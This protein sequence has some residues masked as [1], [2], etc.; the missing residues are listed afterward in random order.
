LWSHHAE[1]AKL[2]V[3]S[4]SIKAGVKPHTITLNGEDQDA[5]IADANMDRRDLSKGQKAMIVAKRYPNDRKGGRGKTETANYA[6]T[7]QL[8]MRRIQ[9]ARVVL[10]HCEQYVPL[11]IDGSMGLDEAY[12]EANLERRDLTKGQKAMLLA[13]RYPVALAHRGKRSESAKDFAAKSI[14]SARISYARA[15][16][17]MCPEMVDAVIDGKTGLDD[18]Y[19]EAQRRRAAQQTDALP[20]FRQSRA[21]G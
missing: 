9:E 21:H 19:T 3:V 14:S 12:R 10:N 7:A 17:S 15:V 16:V 5:F 18:A 6:E 1:V 2:D 8:S 4:H 11:V 20:P 13:V